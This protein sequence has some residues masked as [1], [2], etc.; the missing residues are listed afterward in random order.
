MSPDGSTKPPPEEKLLR[1]I[2]GKGPRADDGADRVPPIA[3]TPARAAVGSAFSVRAQGLQWPRLAIG[4]FGLVVAAEVVWLAVQLTRP[5]PTVRIPDL[6]NPPSV[7]PTAAPRPLD[8]LPSL[9]SSASRPLFA[10]PIET[11]TTPSTTT[12][13]MAPSGTAKLLAS[14]L[15][16]MGI[17]A[18]EPAQAIIED[19]QTRKTFFVTTGQ[20][21]VEGAV[22]EQVL[23]NRVFLHLDGEKIELTL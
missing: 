19:A 20:V 9:A 10:M 6:T 22:L 3:R 7:E 17:V 13:R 18:G 16:L 21:V 2:R 23:D 8:D 4:G 11:T 5:L 14:R 12:P 1:L 15:S